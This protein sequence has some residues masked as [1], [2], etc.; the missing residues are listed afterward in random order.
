MK[1]IYLTIAERPTKD[2]PFAVVVMDGGK[3]VSQETLVRS[4]RDGVICGSG[5]WQGLAIANASFGYPGNVVVDP[6]IE[7]GGC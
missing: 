1:C 7:D 4:R 2:Y 5:I 6:R 3:A